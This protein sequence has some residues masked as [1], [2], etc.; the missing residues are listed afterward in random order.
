MAISASTLLPEYWEM[1]TKKPFKRRH[2][3]QKLAEAEKFHKCPKLP[4][5]LVCDIYSIPF[6][7][8]PMLPHVDLAFQVR[9]ET[10]SNS[11]DD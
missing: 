9:R 4:S 3:D 8:L 10:L 2:A 11:D 7:R 6:V 5:S 1:L